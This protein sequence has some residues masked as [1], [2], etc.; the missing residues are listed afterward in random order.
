M[1]RLN[2]AGR[3]I[4]VTRPRAQN[5]EL[6]RFLRNS[7]AKVIECPTILIK[8]LF[9]APRLR[10]ILT[11][12]KIFSRESGNP[13]PLYNWII[14]LS[15]NGV[16]YFSKAIR[17]LEAV[18]RQI[19]V[20]VVGP[21]TKEAAEKKGFNVGKMG[22]EYNA[23]SLVR[24]LG[25]VSGQRILLPRVKGGPVEVV[26]K[27]K[28]RG[29]Q[30]DEV[31]VYETVP[32]PRP[33]ERVKIQLLKGVDAII[34]SSPSTVRNFCRFFKPGEKRKIFGNCWSLS[35]GPS[36][37]GALKNKNISRIIQAREATHRGIAESLQRLF[38]R[39]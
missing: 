37:T 24:S 29:A 22:T 5:R 30:V 18:S 21:A 25:K 15:A 36:T 10:K 34:F 19:P 33:P 20:C 26:R 28:K 4:V 13:H 6:V 12:L 39:Q 14:F 23:R 31:Y 3:R 32:A 7:S 9:N 1:K 38:R 16:K 11:R 8:P 27:L 17:G 35:I 2:L